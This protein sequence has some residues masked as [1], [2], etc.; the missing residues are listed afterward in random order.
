MKTLILTGGKLTDS[1]LLPFFFFFL[2][3]YIIVVDGAL[4]L[5]HRIGLSFHALVGDFDTVS[6]KIKDLYKDD[7]SI[8]FE[9]HSPRK[10]ETDTQLALDIALEKGA[11]DITILGG[12]GGRL[13]HFFGNVHILKRAL[14]HQIPCSLVDEQNK[15]QLIK[16]SYTISKINQYGTY[17]SLIPFTEKVTGITLKGFAY[18]LSNA[19]ISSGETIGISNEIV[20]EYGSITMEEGIF[21]CIESRDK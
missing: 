20:E 18:P 9:Q 13:D 21:I 6:S 14:E 1:F 8:Y 16:G 5:A 15:I 4:S 11:S 7:S 19:T 10:N 12:T 17:V 2:Y 3:E